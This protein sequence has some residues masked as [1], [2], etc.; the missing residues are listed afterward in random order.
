MRTLLLALL[1]VS[2]AARA[3]TLDEVLAKNLAARGGAANVQNL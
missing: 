3:I 1:A 2:G